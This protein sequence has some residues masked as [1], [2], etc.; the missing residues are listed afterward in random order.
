MST[1]CKNSRAVHIVF[2]NSVIDS[3]KVHLTRIKSR[4]WA[5]ECAINQGCVSHITFAKL[6]SR[7]QVCRFPQKFRP[8]KNWTSSTKFYYL[9]TSSG[10]DAARSVT[11]QTLLTFWQGMTRSHK[12]FT[13]QSTL[14]ELVVHTFLF[15][16]CTVMVIS[17]SSVTNNLV[18]SSSSLDCSSLETFKLTR[19]L[20]PVRFSH[21]LSIADIWWAKSA[22]PVSHSV[23]IQ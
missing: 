14:A 20:R 22:H 18:T 21:T 4:P 10:N 15:L 8:Q 13:V 1:S 5:I 11:C 3:E 19:F 12:I 2:H 9:K 17:G 23:T 6:G 16:M 7:T